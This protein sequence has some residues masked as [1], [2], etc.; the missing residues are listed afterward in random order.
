MPNHTP[1][2]M[3]RLSRE[4]AAKRRASQLARLITT[5][6]PLTEVQVAALHALLDERVATSGGTR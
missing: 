3:R 4:S 2:H 6:P 5:C 1:Q